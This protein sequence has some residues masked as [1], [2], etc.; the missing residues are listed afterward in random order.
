MYNII[1]GADLSLT[2]TGYCVFNLKTGD[3][4]NGVLKPQSRGVSRLSELRNLFKSEIVD[5]GI[6]EYGSIDIVIIEGYAFAAGGKQFD[7][8]EWGGVCKL[9]LYEDFKIPF[10]LIPPTSL[11]KFI[12]GKGNAKKELMRE[13]VFRR[14]GVGS[15]ILST[16]DEVDAYCNK[17]LEI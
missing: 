4:F 5:R 2:S 1:C 13:W 12:V 16:N 17:F 15:E 3:F 11:K 14:Y 10:C 7:I 8:G 6:S 9:A